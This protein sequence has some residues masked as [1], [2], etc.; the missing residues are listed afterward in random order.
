MEFQGRGA[1]HIHGVA[2]SD[3]HAVSKLI[4]EERKVNTILSGK[5][6][7]MYYLKDGIEMSNLENAYKR[8]RENEPLTEATEEALIDF[9]DRSV[10]CSLN[11]DLVAKMIS[12]EKTRDFRMKIVEIVKECMIHYLGNKPP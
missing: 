5:K 6:N 8:L 1:G 4:D 9:V 3:L 10:T 7:N 12:P 11:P 2:W